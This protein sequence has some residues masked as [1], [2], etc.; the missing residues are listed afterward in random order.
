MNDTVT[1]DWE[2][3]FVRIEAMLASDAQIRGVDPSYAMPEND[4]LIL[5]SASEIIAYHLTSAITSPL[6][7]LD[8][9]G[10]HFRH[11][12]AMLFDVLASVENEHGVT[13]LVTD[14]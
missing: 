11:T 4:V 7:A 2:Q 6:T 5:R 9:N 1:V 8:L 12:S 3:T 14:A 13:L 10:P